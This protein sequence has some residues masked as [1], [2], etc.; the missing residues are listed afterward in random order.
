VRHLRCQTFLGPAGCD[1]SLLYS[2]LCGLKSTQVI[3]EYS[4]AEEVYMLRIADIH[5]DEFSCS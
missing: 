5:E 4:L 3:L 1:L 2:G